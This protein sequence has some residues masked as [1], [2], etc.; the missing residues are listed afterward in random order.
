MPL[1]FPLAEMT[2]A[3]VEKPNVWLLSDVGE[4]ESRPLLLALNE[5]A[6]T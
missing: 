2:G 3:A 5:N 1:L 6:L 4:V